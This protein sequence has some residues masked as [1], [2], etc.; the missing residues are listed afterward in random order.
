MGLATV[1][2]VITEI[3]ALIAD[4]SAGVTAIEAVWPE[5]VA[6]E[7]AILAAVKTPLEKLV[8]DFGA[9][10]TNGSTG[11]AIIGDV[12]TLFSDLAGLG[13]S[14]GT[15][16]SLVES[17]VGGIWTQLEAPFKTIEADIAS[18]IPEGSAT[19]AVTGTATLAAT[20]ATT[21]TAGV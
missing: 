15:L 3:P 13:T 21:A 4:F 12:E 10:S 5:A 1:F 6:A 11:Q 19:V 20:P 2:T 17:D 8:S 16:L 18:L 9:F 14:L 7:Q